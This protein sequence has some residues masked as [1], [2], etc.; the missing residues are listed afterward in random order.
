LKEAFREKKQTVISNLGIRNSMDIEGLLRAWDA[1][2][3]LII[4]GNYKNKGN[5]IFLHQKCA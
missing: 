2:G 4:W 3:P 5:Q 1:V